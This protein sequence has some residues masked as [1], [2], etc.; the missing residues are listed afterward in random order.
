MVDKS[1]RK[2][3]IRFYRIV[4][5][6]VLLA[7][8][9]S[10]GFVLI[11]LKWPGYQ[12]YT[13]NDA[14]I[15]YLVARLFIYTSAFLLI[16]SI[17]FFILN[18][19]R[20]FRTIVV[21]LTVIISFLI[22]LPREYLIRS[23]F[24]METSTYELNSNFLNAPD[25]YIDLRLFENAG[26]LS[27]SSNYDITIENKGSYYFND[28]TLVLNFESKRSDLIGNRFIKIE[29]TLKCIDCSSPVN[30]QKLPETEQSRSFYAFPDFNLK[31]VLEHIFY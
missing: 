4:A 9:F 6:F 26:F 20:I 24:G 17:L 14:G 23:V 19:W 5:N 13:D 28:D 21:F 15:I 11:Q 7:L 16:N 22:I 10:F 1:F 8:V 30:L 2:K 3:L 18:H 25:Y 31:S 27:E 29:D 12:T